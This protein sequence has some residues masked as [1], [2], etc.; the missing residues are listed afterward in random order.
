MAY[1]QILK[2]TQSP[3]ISTKEIFAPDT[4]TV[5]DQNVQFKAPKTTR[6]T[7]ESIGADAPYIMINTVPIANVERMIIDETGLVPT[8]RI[9]FT[10]PTGALSGPN[11]PKVDPIMS[12]YVKTANG[13]FK[14]I[15]GDFLITSIKSTL[16]PNLDPA[17]VGINA[18][19]IMM[20]EL[21]IPKIYNNFSKSYSNKTSVAALRELALDLDLGFSELDIDTKDSMTWINP[22]RSGLWMIDHISKHAYINDDAFFDS[23]I[24]RYY[25]LTFVN[26]SNQLIEKA[27]YDTTFVNHTDGSG[28]YP[29]QEMKDKD[30]S[31][32]QEDLIPI[33]L[34]NDDV[35]RG[36]PEFITNYLLE[37]EVGRVLKSRGYRKQ[38][39][40]YD[41]TLEEEKKDTSFWVNPAKVEGQPEDSRL[42]PRD[43]ILQSN[44]I[45]QWINIDY[46]N[47][48]RE[49]N[50]SALINDHNAAELNKVKLKVETSGVNFQIVRGSSIPIRIFKTVQQALD[51]ESYKY[52]RP[53]GYE[54]Y[55]D[56]ADVQNIIIDP[57]LSGTYYTSG[58][59]ISYD[60]SDRYSP[61]RTEFHMRRINW[62]PEKNLENEDAA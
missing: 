49:W 38:I 48:H 43:P 7:E 2:V 52:A 36:R 32:W 37:G 23:F 8:I 42:V 51:Q 61:F 54:D 53:H 40:Y 33:M 60:S 35:M 56:A 12:V 58:I 20:G 6:S 24:D 39:S 9:T 4:S 14:A 15:A 18:T 59:K 28:Y 26:V 31:K 13:K 45:K 19:Y 30:E 11:Y 10:D 3:K 21:Y 22:N 17:G 25:N 29:T 57:Y 27:E 47:N 5:G 46:G 50:A 1:N 55:I 44:L 62:V 16:D 34:T 41:H